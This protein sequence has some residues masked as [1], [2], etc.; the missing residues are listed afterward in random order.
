VTPEIGIKPSNWPN[1]RVWEIDFW[2]DI[3]AKTRLQLSEAK[4]VYD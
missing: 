3:R 1:T 4:Q 2:N